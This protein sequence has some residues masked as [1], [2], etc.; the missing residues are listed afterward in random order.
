MNEITIY[1]E[2]QPPIVIEDD[3]EY[4]ETALRDKLSFL[5]TASKIVKLVTKTKRHESMVILR[6]SKISSIIVKNI[7]EEK[8]NNLFSN[9]IDVLAEEIEGVIEEIKVEPSNA[10]DP[11]KQTVDIITD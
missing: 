6:P 10:V 9:D 5:F 4:D 3:D 2:D 8:I 7:K 11:K 1:Q